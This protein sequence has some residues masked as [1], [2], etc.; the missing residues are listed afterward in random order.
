MINTLLLEIPPTADAGILTLQLNRQIEIKVSA[1]EARRKVNHFVHLE[2]SSQ[3]HAQTP[4]LV[5]SEA[6]W[7]RV[8]VHLT[9]PSFGDV[10]QVGCM[11]VDPITG[12]ITC[13]PAI[14][15]EITHNAENLAHRFA[16]AAAN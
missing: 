6:A 13:S 9:F 14:L 11:D 16:P 1:E 12:D 3:M 7:W 15:A 8:P 4:L 2:I 5:V 10:G